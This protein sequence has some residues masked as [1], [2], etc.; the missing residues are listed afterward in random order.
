M[1]KF[2]AEKSFWT[3]L[4]CLGLCQLLDQCTYKIMVG[5]AKCILCEIN[6]AYSFQCIISILCRYVKVILKMGKKFDAE[7]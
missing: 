1:K 4:Q 3:N 7:I 5:T 2:N 6:F